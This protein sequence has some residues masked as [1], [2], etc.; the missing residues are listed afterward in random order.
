[1]KDVTVNTNV[2]SATLVNGYTYVAPPTITSISPN[3]GSTAG[4]NTVTFTGTGYMNALNPVTGVRIGTNNCTSFNVVN[5]TTLTCVVPARS[6][7]VVAVYV[8]SALGNATLASAYTYVAPP[9]ITS[10]TPTYGPIVGGTTTT[11]TGTNLGNTTGITVG[12]VTCGSINQISTTSVSCVTGARAAGLVDVVLTV[13]NFVSVT[14]TDAFTYVGAPAILS[15]S[16]NQGP[17]AGGTLI[18]IVGTNFYDVSAVTVGGNACTGITVVGGTSITCTTPAGTAGAKTVI[19]TAL[20]GSTPSGSGGGYNAFTYIPPP[21][22][23]NVS[24]ASGVTT[25]GTSVTITGTNFASF[26]FSPAPTDYST[27]GTPQQFQAQVTGQYKLEAWGASANGGTT[28]RGGRG[29]YSVGTVNLIAGQSVYVYVGCFGRV[30]A[31]NVMP[32]QWV[33]GGGAYA[34]NGASSADSGGGGGATDFR[35]VNAAWDNLA[36]LESRI[37]VAGGGGGN[38]TTGSATNA[39]G[40]NGTMNGGQNG[41]WSCVAAARGSFGKGGG[42]ETALTDD[43]GGGGGG[44][45]GGC[46]SG[47]STGGGGSSYAFTSTSDKT[48][49]GANIPN[50]SYYLTGTSFTAGNALM[51]DPIDPTGATTMT[52]RTGNGYARITPMFTLSGDPLVTFATTGD[53]APANCTVTAW[54]ATSISCTTTAH[55]AGLVDV[56][57]Q[58]QGGSVTRT[59]SFTYFVPPTITS[60]SPT[61]GPTTGNTLITITGTNLSGTTGV[62]L[63]GTACTSITNVNATTV[64]CRTPAK[65]AGL[66]A[67]IVVTTS[68]ASASISNAFTYIAAPT[69]ASITPST[70]NLG[71]GN[72]VTIMGTNFIDVSGVTVGG[73]ACTTIITV[74]PT[75]LYCTVPAGAALGAV[76]VIVTAIGGSS[77]SGS[78]PGYNGYTYIGATIT[79]VSPSTGF[80]MGGELITIV[81]TNFSGIDPVPPEPATNFSTCG[82]PV[83]YPVTTTGKYKL[84]VWGAAGGGTS[85]GRGGYSTGEMALTAGSTVT[86]YVGCAGAAPTAGWNG[87]GVGG[88]GGNG[89]GGASDI[90]VGGTALGDRVIIAGGGGGQAYTGAGGSGGGINGI[91]GTTSTAIGGGGGTSSAGGAL[92]TGAGSNGTAGGLGQGGIGG[93]TGNRGGGG[94]GGGYYGGGGGGSN[95]GGG[96]GG[97]GGGGGSGYLSPTLAASPAP[98]TVDGAT[99]NGMPNPS[100][101]TGATL[102]TG[103][104]GN[105]YARITPMDGGTLIPRVTFKTSGVDASPASCTIVDWMAT[106]IRCMTTTHAA[107]LV[108]VLVE[109]ESSATKTDA[110]TYIAPSIIHSIDNSFLSVA[111]APIDT[112]HHT[113]HNMNIKTNSPLGYTVTISM[114][115]ANQTLTGSG[116]A[117]GYSISP[118]PSASGAALGT[119]TWGYSIAGTTDAWRYVPASTSPTILKTTSSATSGGL[120]GLG[121]DTAIHFGFRINMSQKPGTYTGVVVYTLVPNL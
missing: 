51:P 107:G 44:W 64:T 45:Y 69:I 1:M 114:Q 28:S 77:P 116:T 102:M 50:S 60:V 78:G 120:I 105:G 80:T 103:R 8:D 88:S 13:Q 55:A 63:D 21:T 62:T 108:D 47:D 84:E 118:A 66:V 110:F 97:G 56:T 76:T 2:G 29:G 18:T 15:V 7:G 24:P 61:Y 104:Q 92:G 72:T 85:G 101:P 40:Q 11:I 42:N 95:Q 27:C 121:E 9:T 59:N 49:H 31:S 35:L 17:T 23:T 70:G 19:V 34:F 4:G 94:G 99:T 81:G 112:A 100:D 93:A 30:G 79:S 10:L 75:E 67:S 86:V 33:F 91:A 98:R 37:L 87:G 22:I 73:Q 46:A 54:T 25:G 89:G 96:T 90:R 14:R 38:Y 57:V 53:S 113:S 111:P 36:S 117:T 48:G 32:T 12:G 68:V 83:V 65:A 52:G 43:Y 16:P 41:T 119:N 82:T 3:I 20:S 6:A 74:S 109:G 26:N 5:D 115:T 71:G 58:G 39:G 106:Q